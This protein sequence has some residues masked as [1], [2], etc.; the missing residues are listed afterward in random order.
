[1]IT[2]PS[3]YVDSQG[4]R[5]ANEALD[6]PLFYEAMLA[7]GDDTFYLILDGKADQEI[8]AQGME[9]GVVYKGDTIAEL[10]QAAGI[11]GAQLEQTV[12][13]YNSYAHAGEDLQYGKNPQYL[14]A[15]EE[16]SFYA[17]KVVP[18]TLGTLG[19]LRINLKAQVLDPAGNPIPGLYAAGE[20]ANGQLFAAYPASGTSLQV[21]FS[22]G[23]LAGQQA[24]SE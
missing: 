24:A 22:L 20:V 7:N 13:T 3:L 5:F 10:A 21:A 11:A 17:L 23:R 9:L 6:Y 15:I 14:N 19:G 12:S 16:P 18:A 2:T 1:L 4:R 8:L